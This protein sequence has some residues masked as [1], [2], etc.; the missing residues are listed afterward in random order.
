[1]I[2]EVRINSSLTK[3]H[4]RYHLKNR[5]ALRESDAIDCLVV[6]HESMMNKRWQ[7]E[8]LRICKFLNITPVLEE[9]N[10]YMSSYL[11]KQWKRS[12]IA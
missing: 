9:A 6:R 3:S 1:M 8:Y 10:K 5:K 4:L 7:M 12:L 11:N 2:P